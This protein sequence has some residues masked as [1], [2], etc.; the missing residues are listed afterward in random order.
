[1]KRTSVANLHGGSKIL[2]I[3]RVIADRQTTLYGLRGSA[4][5][6]VYKR[7]K[8]YKYNVWVNLGHFIIYSIMGSNAK[9]AIGRI[10]SIQR[11]GIGHVCLR[12][13]RFRRSTERGTIMAQWTHIWEIIPG[14]DGDLWLNT[15]DDDYDIDIFPMQPDFEHPNRFLSCTN[16]HIM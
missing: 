11:K 5:N 15:D 9:P 13:T 3:S 7:V 16:M 8:L 12:L 14:N 10:V 4:P 1:M 2:E 6:G